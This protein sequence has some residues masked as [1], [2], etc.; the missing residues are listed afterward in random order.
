M[1]GLELA[2]V[3]LEVGELAEARAGVS[4]ARALAEQME[5]R[6]LI[7]RVLEVEAEV[8]AVGGDAAA[9]ERLLHEAL[10][11]SKRPGPRGTRAACRSSSPVDFALDLRDLR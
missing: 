5:A 8:A 7:P 6:I 9:Q 11:K 3:A 4:R 10:A 1:P 2:M